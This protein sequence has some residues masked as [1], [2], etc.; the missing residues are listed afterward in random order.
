M[1][2]CVT[3]Y[4]RQKEKSTFL[5]YDPRPNNFSQVGIEIIWARTLELAQEGAKVSTSTTNRG[6]NTCF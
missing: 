1:W 3:W 2:G 6:A 4:Q 5:K